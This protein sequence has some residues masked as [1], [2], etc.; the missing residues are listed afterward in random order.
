MYLCKTCFG[1]AIIEGVCKFKHSYFKFV[2]LYCVE[3]VMTLICNL[4]SLVKLC[5]KIHNWTTTDW[6]QC[7]NSYSA[8]QATC[9]SCFLFLRLSDMFH[10]DRQNNSSLCLLQCLLGPQDAGAPWL[11][12]I[13]KFV[14]LTKLGNPHIFNLDKTCMAYEQII[15]MFFLYSCGRKCTFDDMENSYFPYNPK[16]DV[17]DSFSMF[18]HSFSLIPSCP[19]PACLKK[20]YWHFG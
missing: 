3:I 5:V 15:N 4:K 1:L 6:S 18:P 8:H 16:S 12:L 2:Q 14:W 10:A 20:I 13:I 11:T 7:K 19:A 9:F 17:P